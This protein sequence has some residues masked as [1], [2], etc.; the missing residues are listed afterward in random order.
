MG[1]TSRLSIPLSYK[2]RLGEEQMSV[3]VDT[4]C[5]IWLRHFYFFID[6]KYYILY[7]LSLTRAPPLLR[8]TRSNLESV[9]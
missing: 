5:V 2:E 4:D 7:M 9:C 1:S 8:E 3:S 6:V